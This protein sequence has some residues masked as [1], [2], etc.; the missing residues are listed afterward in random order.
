MRVCSLTRVD[1]VS[2][3]WTERINKH[4]KQNSDVKKGGKMIVYVYFPFFFNTDT[5]EAIYS[6]RVIVLVKPSVVPR[7]ILGQDLSLSR[8]ASLFGYMRKYHRA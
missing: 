7:R 5:T 8:I 4:V 6:E 3:K 2:F 1:L